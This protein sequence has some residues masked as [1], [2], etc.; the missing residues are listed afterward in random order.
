LIRFLLTYFARRS[1]LETFFIVYN[2]QRFGSVLARFLCRLPTI[3]FS[4]GTNLI[5]IA[6]TFLHRHPMPRLPRPLL[7]PSSRLLLG[8][9]R[10]RP[11]PLL[12]RPSIPCY[13]RATHTVSRAKRP[14]YRAARAPTR[15]NFLVNPHLCSGCGILLQ[16]QNPNVVGFIYRV[17]DA[18]KDRA[19]QW[20][21]KTFHDVYDE[22][23]RE[24]NEV[25]GEKLQNTD[26]KTK[27]LEKA[28]PDETESTPGEES[29]PASK[30]VP[31]ISYGHLRLRNVHSGK[32]KQC[33]RCHELKYHHN[34]LPHLTN[35]LPKPLPIE[36]LLSSIRATNTDPLNPPLLVIVLDP[37]DFPLSFFPFTPPSE[38]QV[39][40][41]VNR[42]DALCER[43]SSMKHLRR[44]F[45]LEIRKKLDECKMEIASWRVRCVS[46]KK[47]Y[48]IKELIED[49]F[50]MR[51]HHSN[52][53]FLG[54]KSPIF[55]G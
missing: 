44:Y 17:G 33:R 6:N 23:V 27:A 22:I 50:T 37:V 3:Q 43:A 10:P 55:F 52:V 5:A 2:G 20:E 4:G 9:S 53:Y 13:L 25:L 29:K 31:G 19:Q 54:T 38:A 45:E 14:E 1:G 12:N 32:A 24:C 26:E 42:A 15:D 40:F 35:S 18:T 48:G 16:D 34:R 28:L 46:A 8:S 49:I 30:T 41:V 11:F 7:P 47:G 36:A 51:E 39:L 21:K